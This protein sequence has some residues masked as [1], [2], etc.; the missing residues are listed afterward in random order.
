MSAGQRSRRLS[1]SWGLEL[2]TCGGCVSARLDRGFAELSRNAQLRQVC[3]FDIFKGDDAVPP[4][5]V[6]T[7]FLRK[8]MEQADMIDEMFDLLVEQLQQELD[9]FG[10]VL[11]I[12]GKPIRTHARILAGRRT[13][14]GARMGRFSSV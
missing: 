3:G 10:K 4:S 11:A 5:Y 7:R 9:D 12:D 1:C 6:Y 8:L 14:S 13:M 2:D